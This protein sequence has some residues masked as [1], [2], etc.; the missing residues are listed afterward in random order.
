MIFF[1]SRHYKD[2]IDQPT[3]ACVCQA[4]Y[5]T[6]HKRWIPIR[7][8][9]AV[10]EDLM[11]I[12]NDTWFREIIPQYGSAS[13]D[14][15]DERFK[16]GQNEYIFMY[17]HDNNACSCASNNKDIPFESTEYE[18]YLKNQTIESN[19]QRSGGP[20]WKDNMKDFECYYY[21]REYDNFDLWIENVA[22]DSC[23]ECYSVGSNL[24]PLTEE[25]LIEILSRS[26]GDNEDCT[27]RQGY[28]KSK[29]SEIY[30]CED[31]DGVTGVM[32]FTEASGYTDY[33]CGYTIPT[34]APF[35]APD[36]RETM[37]KRWPIFLVSFF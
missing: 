7:N 27:P 8:E 1:K 3:A 32:S 20:C 19:L 16:T 14:Y 37:E 36:A 17:A 25:D 2:N 31:G 29:K 22:Q 35:R 30:R 28:H 6:P 9:S 11:E 33:E 23:L 21:T 24:W 34:Y 18:I 5:S 15:S 26:E 13:A 12:K 10:N 4:D